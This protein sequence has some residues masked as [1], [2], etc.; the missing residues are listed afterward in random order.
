MIIVDTNILVYRWLPSPRST[1]ADALTR[2]DPEWAAPLLWRSEFR[3][4]ATGYLRAGILNLADVEA[5]TSHAAG[6]LLAGEHSIIDGAVFKLVHR[7]KCS[8]YDCEFVAL[9]EALGTNLITEDRA[10][11]QA[12]P[13]ICRSLGKIIG[14]SKP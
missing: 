5:A 14:K 4:V 11:Q 3:N 2:I 10:L 7:S 13:K 9:A 1:D 6:C 12:F 8:A